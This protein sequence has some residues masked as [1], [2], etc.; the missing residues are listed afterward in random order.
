MIRV[1]VEVA[2]HAA[3]ISIDPEDVDNTYFADYD[4]DLVADWVRYTIKDNLIGAGA[5]SPDVEVY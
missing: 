4:I 1:T 5:Y 2:D 3:S